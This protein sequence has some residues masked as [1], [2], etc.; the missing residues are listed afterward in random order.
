[1]GARFYDSALGRWISAD[2]IVPDPANPQSFNRYS[3]V[4]GNPCRYRDPTGHCIWDGCIL[5][6]IAVGAGVSLIVDYSVQVK[7]NMDRGQSFWDAVFHKNINEGEMVGAA[8]SGAVMATTFVAAGP[9][10]VG[11]YLATGGLGGLL[12]GQTGRFV[13]AGW[14]ESISFLQ[15][16]GWDNTRLLE[17]AAANGLLDPGS[18]AIDSVSGVVAGGFGWVG[19]QLFH[20]MSSTVFSRR[21]PQIYLYGENEMFIDTGEYVLRLPPDK[22]RE[23]VYALDNGLFELARE[24]LAELAQVETSDLLESHGTEP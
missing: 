22:L 20:S 15:G 3:Y 18:I 23:L 16:Q 10:T 1:M 6:I 19:E 13:S 9:T 12:G 24:I 2:T 17:Q 11:G 7:E 8:A 14:D 5:E 21:T 4:L